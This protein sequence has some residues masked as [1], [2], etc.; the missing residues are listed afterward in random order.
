LTCT[1]QILP[2]S[3]AVSVVS[4]FFTASAAGAL[5]STFFSARFVAGASVLAGGLVSAATFSATLT[6]LV[7]SSA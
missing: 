6:S 4:A 3:T 1:R 2:W 7:F 5:I